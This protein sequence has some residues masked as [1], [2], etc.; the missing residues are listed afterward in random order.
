MRNTL[1]RAFLF[2][3]VS[4]L[5]TAAFF[6][7]S[8][9]QAQ[10]KLVAWWDFEKVESDGVSVK[11]VVGGYAG[12][13]NEL[14]VLTAAG[15]GRPGGGKG[16][17]V[18]I[19]SKGYLLHESSGTDNPLNV[20]AADD[21][22]TITVWQK[23]NSNP[24]SSTFWAV[25]DDA[26]RSTQAHLPWSDGTI[27]WDTGGCCGGDTR[28]NQAPAGHDFNAW[29]LY[30]FVKRGT[31]KE[32]WIDG[33]LLKTADGFK[34]HSVLNTKLFIGGEN[35]GNP[36]DAVVDDFV[37]WQGALS[38]EQIAKLAAG[39][40]PTD[41]VID[42]D[43]DGI[44][45]DWEKQY[46]FNANDAA[47][48]KSDFDKDG[49]DNLA[50]Y[51]AGTDPK[52]LT[53]PTLVGA[54]ASASGTTLTITF[55]EKVDPVTAGNV[56]NYS[57]SPALAVTAAAVKGN[58]VTLT[59]AKQ[60]LDGTEYTVAVSNVQDL[61]KKTIV[62]ASK[63][64]A[65][66]FVTLRN[67]IAK[68]SAWLGIS[69]GLQNLYDDAR[70]IA[71]TPD[72]VGA[73][74]GMN[75]RDVFPTDANDNYG[76]TMEAILTP[77]E[78]G[79]YRFFIYTDDASQLFLSTDD[80]AANLAQIAE[81][82]GCCNFFT[83]PE[84]PRTSEPVALTA[85]KKYFIR[86]IYKEG[87]GGDYGQVAWRKEGDAT[88]ASALKPIDGKFLSAEAVASPAGF[89]KSVAPTPKTVQA[90]NNMEIVH[91][92]GRT[93]QT[94]ATTSLEVDGAKVNADIQKSGIFLTVKYTASF[95]PNTKHT[96]KLNYLDVAGKP[97][98]YEWSFSTNPLN[99]ANALFIEAE[100]FDFD[101]GQTITDQKIGMNGKY[102]G[103]AFKDKGGIAGVDFNNPGGNAGQPYRPETGVAAGKGPNGGGRNRGLFDV[104]VSYTVGWND[105]GDW[106]NY[107]R[108]F[109]TPAKKYSVYGFASS[110]GAPIQ[111]NLD[112]VTAGVGTEAQTL[113]PLAE[114]KPGRA[115]AGWDSLELFQFTDPTTKAPAVLELGG[116]KTL[117]ITLPAGNGDMDYFAFIPVPLP[118]NVLSKDDTIVPS[119]A[120]HPAGE[121]APKVIDGLSSTKYLNFDKL[122]TGFTVTPK[123]G[124]SVISA[125]TIT[126]ANDAP[127]RDPATWQILGSN[128]GTVFE[129]VA[130]GSLAA[131]PTRFTTTTL[132]FSNTKSYT[133]YKLVFPTVVDAAKANS[134]QVAEIALLG[135]ASGGSGG[136][137]A[138][139]TGI[140]ANADGTV[141][142]TWTGAGKLQ[143]SVSL[144]GPWTDVAGA[145][146]PLTVPANQAAQFAR[147]V[148]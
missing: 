127:E 50:E 147:I 85:G 103:D 33:T 87:G 78:S 123:A 107:T 124:A 36:P 144:S 9:V 47:D 42:T 117:R 145:T 116:K 138:R 11:S 100:D 17:D 115:T 43:K 119:S 32:I 67:G 16:F 6:T 13:I 142:I 1:N 39:A 77:V 10:T 109:P 91:V 106:Q 19:A 35:G 64:S 143:S 120:N 75:S 69:G 98:T 121:A 71:G 45:D 70:Y 104:D 132:E 61:S 31:T 83:E 46:G 95:A 137:D 110:G 7:A 53:P 5:P 72:V 92:D 112:E 128:N 28:L 125:I 29:H 96:A 55:S 126:T 24:N 27:Y 52:D 49:F 38:K 89:I 108:T 90:G 20:A 114:L 8:Q 140:K 118:G 93:V 60:T 84:S 86:L 88:P 63:V 148:K 37:I 62:A 141:T 14:A 34:A 12:Q 58:T 15:G 74:F 22:I 82:T 56:A 54:A 136:G 129:A 135:T 113:K 76:A 2:G 80:K 18:S 73:M 44:P 25:A 48:A 41:L 134:M 102:P 131:N 51:T 105:A 81:E 66:A 59:T 65:Y 3:L 23:N 146:S 57:V 68:F 94:A 30:S 40:K 97:T 79:S 122:N 99:D 4:F 139:F 26:G 133:S 130:S 111:F 21:N 101:G